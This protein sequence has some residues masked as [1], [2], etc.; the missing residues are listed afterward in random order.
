MTQAVLGFSNPLSVLINLIK[1]EEKRGNYSV[2]WDLVIPDI[3]LF[4]LF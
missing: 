2:Y 3:H 4:A 1:T